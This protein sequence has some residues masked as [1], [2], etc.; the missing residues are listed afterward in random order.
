MNIGRI[1]LAFGVAALAVTFSAV[2][3]VAQPAAERTTDQYLCK[4]IMRDGGQREVAIAFIH[5]I[6]L[7]KSGDTKFNLETMQ[8][9]TD[10]FID[11]CLDNPNE[12]AIDAMA[13][14]KK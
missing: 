11:H 14:V 5:G 4:D 8:K 7:G 9:Q 10:S 2:P 13:K 1:K 12:K 3:V 6:F